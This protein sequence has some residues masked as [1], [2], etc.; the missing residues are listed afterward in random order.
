MNVL[1]FRVGSIGDSVVALPAFSVIKELHQC[2]K[3]FLLC[4][5]HN[6][7]SGSAVSSYKVFKFFSLIDG[8]YSYSRRL[9]CRS[10]KLLIKFI[11]KNEI[12]LLYYLMPRRSFFQKFRDFTFFKLFGLKIIGINLFNPDLNLYLNNALYESE[13][14]RLL[15]KINYTGPY[16]FGNFKFN[17]KEKLKNTIAISIGTKHTMNNW[18]YENWSKLINK[19]S[20]IPHLKI[21]FIGGCNDRESSECLGL[22]LKGRGSFSNY[23]GTASIEDAIKIIAKSNLFI[24]HD[25]G[26]MHLASLT[27]TEIIAIFSHKNQ[28][29]IWYPSQGNFHIFRASNLNDIDPDAVFYLADNLI[30]Q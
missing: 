5:D 27:H 22:A 29:G 1:I 8:F 30:K 28:Q 2:D 3:V 13:A 9:D 10:I 15:R 26:P 21:N 6:D 14:A 20:T 18:G 7:S 17:G 16:D 25:S 19:L 12:K 23:C 4:D 11:K 24:G